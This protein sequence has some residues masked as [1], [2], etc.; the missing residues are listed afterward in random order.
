MN[1]GACDGTVVAAHYTG[2]R[3]QA[4]GKG[5][6]IKG[7]D[8]LIADLCRECHEN[9]DRHATSIFRDK[10]M[11]QIDQSEQFLYCV[12]QTLIRRVQEGVLYTDDIKVKE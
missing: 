6:G 2:L 4:F 7:H 11:R 10:P 9:F 12:A 1:C 8:L 3:Q 5:T